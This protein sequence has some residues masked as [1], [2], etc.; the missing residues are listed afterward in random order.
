MKNRRVATLAATVMLTASS[1][2]LAVTPAV[3]DTSRGGCTVYKPA[4]PK[5]DGVDGSNRVMIKWIIDVKCDKGRSIH[6][7]QERWEEDDN[8]G[9]GRG[10][11]YIWYSHFD[12]SFQD[13]GGTHRFTVRTR[14][15][16]T[17]DAGGGTEPNEEMY[18]K[19]RFYVTSNGVTSSYTNFERGPASWIFH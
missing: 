14:L 12:R 1:V 18:Q 8:T 7:H 19:V 13:K 10:D 5:A 4:G 16:Q 17:K 15:P 3:A 2:G 11:D 6:V 9:K